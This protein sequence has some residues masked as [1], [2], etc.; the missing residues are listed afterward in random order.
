MAIQKLVTQEIARKIPALY[1]QDG[2]DNPTVY[3]KLFTPSSSWT[4]LVTEYDPASG[5]AFGFAYDSLFPMGAELGYISIPELQAL[6]GRFGQAV[7]RDTSFRPKP[8]SEALRAECDGCKAD[9]FEPK[10]A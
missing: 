6:R 7:E 9:R 3:L 10:A 2:V 5:Q 1:A 8:M 4:W